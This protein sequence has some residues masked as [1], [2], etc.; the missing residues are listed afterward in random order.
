MSSILML[1]YEKITHSLV[2][3]FH[4]PCNKKKMPFFPFESA[5]GL[6]VMPVKC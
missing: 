6:A 4:S 3:A 2:L 5:H 1:T